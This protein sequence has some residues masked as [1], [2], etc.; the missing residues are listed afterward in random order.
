MQARFSDFFLLVSIIAWTCMELILL[1]LHLQIIKASA[2]GG[3]WTTEDLTCLHTCIHMDAVR[4]P[5]GTR[6]IWGP[7]TLTSPPL[8][9]NQQMCSKRSGAYR[10]NITLSISAVG[11]VSWWFSG[12]ASVPQQLATTSTAAGSLQASKD[13]HLTAYRLAAD[14]SKAAHLK[15]FNMLEAGLVLSNLAVS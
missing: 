11:Y 10:M 8:H 15:K 1:I 6:C 4:W 2:Q 13:S 3:L 5:R 9:R 12:T 7:Y 14:V